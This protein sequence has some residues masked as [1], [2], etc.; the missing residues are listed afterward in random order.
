MLSIVI[1]SDLYIISKGGVLLIVRQGSVWFG[2]LCWVFIGNSWVA[3]AE[4]LIL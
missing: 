1:A 4:S 2:E 3:F